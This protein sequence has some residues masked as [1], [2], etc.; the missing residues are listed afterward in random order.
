M[1]TAIPFFALFL[2]WASAAAQPGRVFWDKT[3][4]GQQTEEFTYAQPTPDGGTIQ[5]SASSSGISGDRTADTLGGVDIWVVKTDPDGDPEWDIALGGAGDDEPRAVA[6]LSD[7][8][9]VFG[10]SDSDIGGTKSSNSR[11]FVDYWLVKLD[12]NGN[13]RW[14]ST[15]GGVSEEFPG[16]LIVTADG[17]LLVGS[18]VSGAGGEK[19]GV[20]RGQFD[21]WVVQTDTSGTLLWEATFGSAGTDYLY[22]AK[23][24]PTGGY[25]LGAT[26]DGGANNEKTA[27]SRGANDFWAIRIN[28]AGAI[29]WDSTYGSSGAEFLGEVLVNPGG[30]YALVGS[31]GANAP[32]NEMTAPPLGMN[33]IWALGID[34]NGTKQ[35]DARYG[36]TSTESIASFVAEAK[37]GDALTS[38][39][40]YTILALSDSDIG[41]TKTTAQK[42]GFDY[43]LIRVSF[44][45]TQLWDSTYGGNNT[46]RPYAIGQYPSGRLLL[47]GY[48]T[49]DVSGDKTEPSQGLAD[50]WVLGVCDNVPGTFTI[51]ASAAPL[52]VISNTLPG[53]EYLWFEVSGGSQDSTTPTFTAQAVGSYYAWV[54]NGCDT[55]F[56]DTVSVTSVHR[57]AEEVL[58]GFT[59]YPNPTAGTLTVE[60]PATGTLQL[61]DITGRVLFEEAA[62][63]GKTT[64]NIAQLP[65]GTYVLRAEAAAGVGVQRIVLTR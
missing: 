9:L 31:C 53:L 36:G 10:G 40:G 3:L 46:D 56:T 55:V 28:N 14:D 49:S 61:L 51:D 30:G 58:P 41:G 20:L 7:G 52:L 16:D 33:D 15:Y 47:G 19:S 11:G 32:D 21:A 12:W 45:G 5:V 65:V 1:K 54:T 42:G 64:L 63:N 26:S 34:A 24:A 59:A 35:W 18:T 38:P 22:T 44:N 8:Y 2:I 4:G 50:N 37:Y 62:Q 57:H 39:D 48:S 29:L 60:L 13:I 17:Y 25:L 43:W 6:V 23:A 27:P